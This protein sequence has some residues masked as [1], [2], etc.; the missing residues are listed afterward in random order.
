VLLLLLLLVCLSAGYSDSGKDAGRM[1]AAWALFET[2]EKIVSVADEF[3]V[4]LI[5]FHGR[6]GSVGRGGGPTH[7]AIRSQP[8]GTI[9][10]RAVQCR[11]L[12][13]DNVSQD[14]CIAWGAAAGSLG[15]DVETISEMWRGSANQLC[16]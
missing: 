1:A 11:V 6:G 15:G 3:G 8:P 14:P 2:Q 7:M 12:L 9:K 4:R 5:L 10:V 13:Q 16:G